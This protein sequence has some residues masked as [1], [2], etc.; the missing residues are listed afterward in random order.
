MLAEF[1]AMTRSEPFEWGRNDCALWCSSAVEYKIGFD[2][3]CDLRGTYSTWFECRNIVIKA[4]GLLALVSDRM[5]HDRLCDLHGDGFAILK[6]GG[7]RICGLILEG[8][9]IVKTQSGI[10]IADD[11]KVLRGWSCRKQ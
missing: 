2:P 7:Q 10:R 8:R 11:F 1:I 5:T 9:A 3:A 6:L 4:G